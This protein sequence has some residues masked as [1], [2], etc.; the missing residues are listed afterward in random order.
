MWAPRPGDP[1]TPQY[2]QFSNPRVQINS[3]VS[4][5]DGESE[6]ASTLFRLAPVV[7]GFRGPASEVIFRDSFE[8]GV[9]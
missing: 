2:L 9:P 4:G 3:F 7:A 6:N 8:T 5:V 1:E